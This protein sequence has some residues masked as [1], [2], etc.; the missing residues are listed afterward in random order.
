MGMRVRIYTGNNKEENYVLR[1][2]RSGCDADDVWFGDLDNYEPSDLAVVFGTYK[3][4]IPVSYRRGHVVHEQKK[5]GLDT[6]IIE[7]GYLN[8]GAGAHHHYA[9]GLNGLNGRAD[10]KNKNSPGDRAAQFKVKPWRENGNHILVCGQVPWD[11]SVDHIDFQKWA[12]HIVEVTNG[13]TDRP[14]IYRSHPL[15]K[16]PAPFGS[17][18]SQNYWLEDDL[19]DCWCV[20]TF[21]S[22]SGVDAIMA[23]VP[24]VAMDEGSMILPVSTTISQ[25]NAPSKPDREQWL[26][27][28]SYAQWTPDEIAAGLTWAHLFK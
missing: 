17:R 2:F 28:L 23:G 18:P 24:A 14:I 12:Q 25:I 4:Q 5:H 21:N 7:T 9:V 13:L 19:K 10:F 26:N 6:I 16:T 3:K 11:A 15:G 1:C 22:N 20:V 8:R 27:D